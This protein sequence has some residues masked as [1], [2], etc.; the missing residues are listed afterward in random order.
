[1]HTVVNNF[2]IFFVLKIL[3]LARIINAVIHIDK[4]IS[5]DDIWSIIV[6][7]DTITNEEKLNSVNIFNVSR[8]STSIEM[9]QYSGVISGRRSVLI[10][11]KMI[12]SIYLKLQIGFYLIRMFEILILLMLIL[13]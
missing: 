13:V 10:V 7:G 4:R 2:G 6:I 9:C 12:S 8:I 3:Y 11:V 5:V 1:V